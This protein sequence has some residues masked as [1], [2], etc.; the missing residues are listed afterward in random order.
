[1]ISVVILTKNEE[2]NIADCLQSL[3]WCDEIIV[4]DD[5]STDNTEK[6]ATGLSLKQLIFYKHSLNG[7]FGESRNFGLKKAKCEWVLFI[8]ADERVSTSLQYEIVSSINSSIENYNGYFLHRVDE[9]WGKELRFGEAGNIS[10]LRLGRKGSGEW[11]GV[12]HEVWD[13]KGRTGTLKNPLLHHPHQSVSEFLSEI[14]YYTDLR[15]S[16]L[17]HK[18]V[19]VSMPDVLFYPAVKFIQN[20]FLK[21]GFR[22]GIPGLIVAIMM[23]FHSFLVRGKLWQLWQKKS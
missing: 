22:D 12:V 17:W 5:Y 1:M 9:L 19:K 23:S 10:L 15:A 7:N 20:Y 11:K 6:I 3:R 21:Q 8:D 18:K 14:N 13:I 16:E 2:K 4:V